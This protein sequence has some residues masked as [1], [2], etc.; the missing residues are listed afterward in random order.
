VNE[1]DFE[2]VPETES[3]TAP[4]TL[5]GYGETSTEATEAL[6]PPQS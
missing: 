6:D 2:A 3:V 5:G 4:P 1:N